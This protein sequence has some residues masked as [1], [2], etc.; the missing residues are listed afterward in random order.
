MGGVE[1]L[2]RRLAGVLEFC[3]EPRPVVRQLEGLAHER[4]IGKQA[5]VADGAGQVR[6][7]E[8]V[9][10][11]GLEL[12]MLR[13]K[14]ADAEPSGVAPGEPAEVTLQVALQLVV[15]MPHEHGRAGRGPRRRSA[16]AR[17]RRACVMPL[18]VPC[19]PSSHA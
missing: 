16:A 17:A 5:S 19:R 18:H 9:V 4:R 11:A 2:E 7:V 12:R 14:L 6:R 15:H 3:R 10:A 13:N 1:F 8:V